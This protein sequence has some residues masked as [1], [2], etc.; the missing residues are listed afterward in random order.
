M[1]DSMRG[2]RGGGG[3][4]GGGGGIGDLDPLPRENHKCNRFL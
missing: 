3:G 4:G 2:Y 1:T